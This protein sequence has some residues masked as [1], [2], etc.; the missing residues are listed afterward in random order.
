[1]KRIKTGGRD[2]G[3]PNQLTKEMRAILNNVIANEI[4]KLQEYLNTLEPEKRIEIVIKLL[5]YI[6][7]KL[8]AEKPNDYIEPIAVNIITV[9][10]EGNIKS[11]KELPYPN[12]F[13]PH[14]I[15]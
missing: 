10:D 15:G 13:S 5:P 6:L 14:P 4:D 8:E 11:K 1:M 3:T 7:P 9:D 2:K 12:Y